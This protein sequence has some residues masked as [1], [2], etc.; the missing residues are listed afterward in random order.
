M[1]S[2]L[3][4]KD[5]Y[6]YQR[7]SGPAART[8]AGLGWRP[9]QL[10]LCPCSYRC[11]PGQWLWSQKSSSR[12]GAE[13]LELAAVSQGRVCVEKTWH[14]AVFL[15]W[16][17]STRQKTNHL[18]SCSQTAHIRRY[19]NSFFPWVQ[20]ACCCGVGRHGEGRRGAK[21][22]W[23]GL[24][25]PCARQQSC[26]SSLDPK[27]RSSTH[28]HSLARSQMLQFCSKHQ[29]RPPMRLVTEAQKYHIVGGRGL[30]ATRSTAHIC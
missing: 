12:W 30:A 21:G 16:V 4:G 1:K 10:C 23:W 27:T 14:I 13:K 29:G 8:C 6:R 9:L 25:C 15:S 11:K 3:A 17:P 24:F 7:K 5:L 26:S 2:H 18:A 22:A 28:F 20:S 19:G